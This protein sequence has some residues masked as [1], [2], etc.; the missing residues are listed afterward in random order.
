[1]T[2]DWAG[3]AHRL[4]DDLA[5]AGDLHDPAWRAAVAAVP[6]HAMVPRYHEQAE[7]GTWR[8]VDA[9]DPAYWDAVYSDRTLLTAL[10]EVRTR[11][12]V[13]RVPVSSSTQPGLLVRLL[14]RL[15]LGAG[16]QVLEIGTGTGYNAG[17]LSH[18]LDEANVFSVDLRPDLIDLARDRLAGCGY[19]PV[20][21]ARDGALGLAEY[22]PFDRLIATCAVPA[23]PPAWIE[24]TRPGGLILADVQGSLYAGNIA[25]LHR[26]GNRAEGRFLAEWAAFMPMRHSLDMPPVPPAPPDTGTALAWDTL[27]GPGLLA[28]PVL[29]FFAQLHLP[30]G[31]TQ[32]TTTWEDGATATRLISP[33]GAWC[34]VANDPAPDGQYRV[35]EAGPDALWARVEDAHHRWRLAGCPGWQRFGVTATADVQYVWLDDPAGGGSWPLT[36]PG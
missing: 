35:L 2:A 10:A 3:L 23:V 1:V 26:V 5:A 29:A 22:A 34:E 27:V 17:L 19:R 9:D 31:T 30:A 16:L 12:G 7:D 11:A 21:V 8:T 25:A 20:L 32:R 4:A 18:R 13:Q 36:D 14:E 24:Q 15:D 33:D 6:R 28:E